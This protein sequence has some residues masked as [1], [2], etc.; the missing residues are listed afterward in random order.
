MPTIQPVTRPGSRQRRPQ[1]AA[2]RRHADV[3]IV[4]G[5]G[6]VGLPLA[7]VLASQ[8][9]QVL[10]YDVNGRA[11][12]GIKRGTM[13]F[14]EH[15]AGP[16]L[17][18]A[19]A[20][21]R[22]SFSSTNPDDLAG[23]PIII[24]TIGTPID[25]FLNPAL[26]SMIR[27]FEPLLPRLSDHQ[28]VILRSTVYPGTTDWLHRYLRSH[29][30]RPQLAFCPE[31]I[32]QGYA[33]QELRQL[34][35]IVSGTTQDAED[36]AA[37]FFSQLAPLIVRLRPMEAEFAK[38]FCN[39]YRY[40]QFAVANEFYMIANSAGLDYYRILAGLKANYSRM[41]DLPGAGFA[42]G[43]C[44]F[45]DTMQLTG[46]S[47]NQFQLGS[48]AMWINEGL[49]LY[50]VQQ[51]AKQYGLS[52]MTVGLLGM[53]FKANSDDPRASLS[54]KLK[55]ALLFHAKRVLTTSPFVQGDPDI[56]PLD[57]VISKSDLLILC[58]PHD[59]YRNLDTKGKPV[60]D[61]WNFFGKGGK[62]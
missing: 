20:K 22:L 49:P 24:V 28:L 23:V 9:Q 50:V 3:C 56:V 6:H 32:V 11:L 5:A 14:L 58:V 17:K 8:G 38:L 26:K 52:T 51:L 53:A 27:A 60:V 40:I 48:M 30:K 12:N 59:A 1:R 46:F 54:Y 55:K 47:N 13:P 36:R 43:P 62:I 15:G 4:G 61:V 33:I 19:L 34:P 29:G 16:L 41:R 35:Q 18:D 10:L 25:E 44:L 45:K 37:E 2:S 21:K 39:A 7:L 31:R 42:A 57:D